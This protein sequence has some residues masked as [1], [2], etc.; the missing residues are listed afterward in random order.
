MIRLNR[1]EREPAPHLRFLAI[2]LALLV[3]AL[4]ALAGC[5]ASAPVRPDRFYRL[6]AV[7]LEGA[8]GAPVP[9]ILMVNH[10]ASRGFM[11][12][13]QVV[14]RTREEPLVA[15]R[16][17][18]LLWEEP[19]ARAIAE[20]LVKGLRAAEVFQFVVVPAERARADYLLGGEVERFEHLPTDRPPRVVASFHLA[21]VRASDRVPLASRAYSGEEI[22]DAPTSEAMA[23]AFGRL[24]SRLI[25][26]AVRD[27]QALGP[28]LHGSAARP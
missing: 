18:D 23:D 24:T 19:P 4:T 20:S 28:A 22:V 11:G 25:A 12:G 2:L 17:E 26:E 7:P 5:G 10:L 8:S 13:R 9:A 15:Q 27:L 14:F 1:G 3:I 21:L 16:Y 6:E